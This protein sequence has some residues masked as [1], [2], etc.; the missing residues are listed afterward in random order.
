MKLFLEGTMAECLLVSLATPAA[1]VR[2][3]VPPPLELLTDGGMAFWNIAFC[4]VNKMRPSG[5]PSFAGIDYSHVAYRLYVRARL[6]NGEE[7]R[8]LYF[9]RSDVDSHLICRGSNLLTDFKC[10]P[11]TIRWEIEKDAGKVSVR[12]NGGNA[13]LRFHASPKA[14]LNAA[15]DRILK[16]EPAGL[17]I[18]SRGELKV[19][20]VFRDESQWMEEP[21]EVLEAEWDFLESLGEM[22]REVVRATRVRPL[23][24]RWALGKR[25]QLAKKAAASLVAS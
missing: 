14:K 22:N 11:A 6:G 19:A 23:P 2:A 20:E 10:H 1:N 17:S 15:A 13:R 18:D 7:Q 25:A 8:G 9:L 21:I 24:Y 12:S 3:L 16:Y 5:L 4:R